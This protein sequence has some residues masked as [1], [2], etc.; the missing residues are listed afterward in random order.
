MSDLITTLRA[1]P[2]HDRREAAEAI[3][4]L[5]AERDALRALLAEARED[6]EAYV[7]ADYPYSTREQYPDVERK[8]LRDMDL[9]WRIDAALREARRE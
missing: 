5:I 2:G 4:K 7:D 6:L 1:G 8:Y 9:C 3:E